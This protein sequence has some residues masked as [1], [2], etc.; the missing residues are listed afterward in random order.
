MPI[1]PCGVVRAKKTN[2]EDAEAAQRTRRSRL[3]LKAI[4]DPGDPVAHVRDIEIEKIAELEVAETKIAEQLCAMNGKKR[5]D[6]HQF[7]HDPIIDQQIN[8]TDLV[9]GHPLRPL[10]NL[11]ALCV[12]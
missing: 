11:R 5:L 4:Y 3:F 1:L 8:S 6:R 12:R 10:R 9:L 2:A 7:H